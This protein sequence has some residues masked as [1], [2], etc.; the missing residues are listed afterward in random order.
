MSNRCKSILDVKLDIELFA[1][2]VVNLQ[3]IV[4][5][6]SMREL[7]LAYDGLSEVL[8]FVLGNVR[9][10]FCLYP[11]SEVI[12]GDDEKLLLTSLD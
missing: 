8:E 11:F 4:D 5:D 7:K 6:D 12:D 3:V 1:C 2:L 10:E 9:R